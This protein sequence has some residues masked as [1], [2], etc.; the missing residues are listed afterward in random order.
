MDKHD[1]A[2]LEPQ[3]DDADA[4]EQYE[5]AKD[6][7]FVTLEKLQ[8]QAFESCERQPRED[9]HACDSRNGEYRTE[10]DK[11]GPAISD[12]RKID[13]QETLAGRE[14]Q[15][16]K[17]AEDGSLIGLGWLGQGACLRVDRAWGF[18]VLV[19]LEPNLVM[20]SVI[21]MGKAD[22]GL[23]FVRFGY[24]FKGFQIVATGSEGEALP[25]SI[26]THGLDG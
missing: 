3:E 10:Q 6:A 15:E 4:K 7:A 17:Q 25:G 2:E 18:I 22:G 23:E 16:S 20:M 19:L 8:A 11:A 13:R 26:R 14:R 12:P 9:Y 5:R 21:A 24:H 1:I